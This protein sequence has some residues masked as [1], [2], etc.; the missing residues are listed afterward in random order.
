[1]KNYY[2]ENLPTLFPTFGDSIFDEIDNAFS[3]MFKNPINKKMFPYPVN[4]YNKVDLKTN[5]V[6]S[7]VIEIALA[8]FTKDEIEVRA[9]KGRELSVNINAKNTASETASERVEYVVNGIS[10]R[11]GS[12]TWSLSSKVDLDNFHPVFKNG[13]LTIELP[14]GKEDSQDEIIGVIED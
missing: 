13:L 9:I 12:I 6:I 11:N 5:K 1:M 8:G 7:T 4:I 14:I 3:R 10:K 2:F